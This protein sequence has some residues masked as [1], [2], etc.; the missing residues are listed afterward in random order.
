MVH[1][2]LRREEWLASGQAADFEI[3]GFDPC[4]PLFGLPASS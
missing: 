3:S 2:R 4:R 1:L